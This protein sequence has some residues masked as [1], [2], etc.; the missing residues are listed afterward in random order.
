MNALY[1]NI[2]PEKLFSVARDYGADQIIFRILYTSG[3]NTEQDQWIE[4]N[5][6][7]EEKITELKEYIKKQGRLLEIMEFGY[8]RFSVS[9]IS[10]V[11]DDDC[12]NTHAKDSLKYLILRPDCKLYSKWDEPGS[13]IF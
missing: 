10:T 5:L 3:K 6:Y 7:P 1:N 2:N 11:L 8:S 4:Q 12:M 9:G 13:L